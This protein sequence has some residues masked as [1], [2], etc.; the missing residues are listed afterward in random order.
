[1][2]CSVDGCA[3]GVGQLGRDGDPG[4]SC[5]FEQ[6]A[7]GGLAEDAECPAH[8][9]HVHVK[10]RDRQWLHVWPARGVAGGL[11]GQQVVERRG[12]GIAA[13]ERVAEA[14]HLAERGDHR[15]VPVL[16][17]DHDPLVHPGGD[18]DGRHPVAGAVESEVEL[19]RRRARVRWGHRTW[20]DVIVGSAGLVPADE[21]QRV[22]RV[23]PLGEA[24]D[25][26][27]L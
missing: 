6:A 25:R 5:V 15:R 21:E 7:A 9:H 8:L 20:W 27:V 2:I 17:V 10:L 23:G 22:V 19:S 26:I 16:V 4:L 12:V 14:P 18:D 3:F 13:G 24:A 1:M 11:A